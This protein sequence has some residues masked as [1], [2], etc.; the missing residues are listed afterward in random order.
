M[1]KGKR[2][3]FIGIGG[4]GM[5]G[6]AQILNERGNIVSGSDMYAS[7]ITEDM[8]KRG[9]KIYIG[10]DESNLKKNIEKVVYSSAIPE[11]N[12]ELLKAKKLNMEMM[13]FPRAVGDFSKNMFTIA[14]CGTHGKTTVTSMAA[15]AL[16][17]GDK[18]PTVIVGSNLKEFENSNHRLG[19]S[20]CFVVEACEYKRNFLNYN[21]KVIILNNVEADH[22]DYYK[23]LEDYKNAFVEFIQK[24]PKDGYLIANI[25]DANVLD[26]IK[27]YNGNLITFGSV[28]GKADWVLR[29]NKIE[30]AGEFV[31]EFNLSIPGSFNMMNALAVLALA[32]VLNVERERTIAALN[33][34][35]GAWRRF[36]FVGEFNN[37]GLIS[38]YAH[39]PTEII[40][41]IKAVRERY[42]DKKVCCIFQPHQY[43][44]TKNLLNGF[45]DSLKEADTVI[46]PNIYKVRDTQKDAKSISAAGI[47]ELIKEKGTKAYNLKTYKQIKD[48]LKKNTDQIEVAI[49]MGAGDIW[50]FGEYIMNS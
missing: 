40:N 2:L 26:V 15:L 4:I 9:I 41:T 23:D 5:S 14:V 7:Q 35:K 45:V 22:L 13:T 1:K 44:R 28:N 11:S 18:D 31:C 12:P 33:N 34:F 3:H 46:I 21:P 27:N 32:Q 19:K 37:I 49:I 38:D 36:E 20:D 30:K 16:I 50:E 17:A 25:D 47:V 6:L 39:H 42:P 43:N 24:L 8:K 48:Y 10:H 29:G